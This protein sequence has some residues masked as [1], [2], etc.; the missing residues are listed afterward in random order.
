MT[1]ILVILIGSP[2]SSWQSVELDLI[3]LYDTKIK[4][5]SQDVKR[6]FIKISFYMRDLE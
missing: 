4:I 6:V 5:K 2:G 3:V 1:E